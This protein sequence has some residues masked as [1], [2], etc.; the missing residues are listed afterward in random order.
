MIGYIDS[1]TFINIHQR[2]NKIL[3][4]SNDWYIKLFSRH[5]R[6]IIY[7]RSSSMTFLKLIG[8][9]WSVLHFNNTNRSIS[10][11]R[12]ARNFRRIFG[13][14][15]EI[16]KFIGSLFKSNKSFH[17]LNGKFT[18]TFPA[19]LISHGKERGLPQMKRMGAIEC[20]HTACY[21]LL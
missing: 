5:F 14:K 1:Y 3:H 16:L 9:Y 20:K 13:Y 10:I 2:L 17:S 21:K 8:F 7:G 19:A 15:K 4:Q 18:I 6:L 12:K 11:A